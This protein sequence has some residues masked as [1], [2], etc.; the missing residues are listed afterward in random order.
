MPLR[1]EF[2]FPTPIY[3]YDGDTRN[4]FENLAII[5]NTF[6]WGMELKDTVPNEGVS[7]VGGYQTPFNYD[8]S[9]IPK[10]SLEY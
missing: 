3:Y 6:N 7:N 8:F 1:Q 9:S 5:K 4:N 2:Y 10:R